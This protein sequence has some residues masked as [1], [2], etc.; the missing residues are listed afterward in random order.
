M[1]KKPT[2]KSAKF[3]RV[4][5]R[6][7]LIVA[8]IIGL[9]LVISTILKHPGHG[10]ELVFLDVGQG[11]S[12]LIKTPGGQT[13]LIDGGPDNKVLQGLGKNMSFYRRRLD[14]IIISHYHDDHITGLIEIIKRYRVGTIIYSDKAP[15]S[16]LIAELLRVA[17][18]HNVKLQILGGQAEVSF[19]PN[20]NLSLL[21]PDILGVKE[22]PN[23]SLVARLSCANRRV[24]F[25]GDNNS[26]VEKVLLASDWPLKADILKASH[27]GSNTS[28]SAA[29]LE[30][31]APSLIAVSVGADNRFGHP[32]KFFLDRAAA[33]KLPVKR[34][35]AAGNL[36]I[37]LK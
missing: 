6:I 29:W 20:C 5:K 26:A 2:K 13:V 12:A 14:F 19:S 34:T 21:N 22:D 27:H 37:S 17:V 35:D 25:A 7:I 18:Q 23:N 8:I 28:N 1:S 16:L 10:L 36:K 31:V 24:L 11:D 9:I 4:G 3:F 33:L 32:G 15:D 30:T